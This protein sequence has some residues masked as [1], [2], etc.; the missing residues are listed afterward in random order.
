MKED[1]EDV[2]MEFIER[3][4]EWK[5]VD[6]TMW[7]EC[8]QLTTA[9]YVYMYHSLYIENLKRVLKIYQDKNK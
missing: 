9:R 3:A 4:E 5:D 1:F 6:Y 8:D 7:I 2:L